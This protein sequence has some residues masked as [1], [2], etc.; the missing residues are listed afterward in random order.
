[1][2]Q[3]VEENEDWEE[4]VT[5]KDGEGYR[6][7]KRRGGGLYQEHSSIDSVAR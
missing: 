2:V 3:E 1:M 6:G 5:G 7:S 4:M